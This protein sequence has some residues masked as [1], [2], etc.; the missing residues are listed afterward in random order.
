M[1]DGMCYYSVL[2][3]DHGGIVEDGIIAKFSDERL[4]WIGGPGSAEEWLYAKSIG[5][6]VKIESFND[7]IHV[8]SIQ[9]PKS[10]EILQSVTKSDLSAVPFFGLFVSEVCGAEVTISRT[11]YTAELGYDIYVPVAAGAAFFEALRTIVEAAD[12]KLCGSRSLGIRRVEASILNF[13][14]DFDWQHNPVEVGLGWMVSETKAPWCAG[15]ILLAAKKQKPARSVIGLRF[16]GDEIPLIGDTVRLGDQILGKVTSA[17]GSPAL[18][19][20]IAMSLIEGNAEPGTKLLVEAGEN[21][22][23]VEVVAMP[24]FDP[25]RKLSRVK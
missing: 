14:Q 19:C 3:H 17:I 9:G 2:C 15:D 18:G 8:A 4:W 20:P 16:S 1:K 23:E 22:L 12:G 6:N 24:F 21:V 7:R 10:R 13:G 25:E 11:G 5:R